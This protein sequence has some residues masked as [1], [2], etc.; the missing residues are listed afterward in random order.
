M[1]PF[2]GLR[3]YSSIRHTSGEPSIIFHYRRILLGNV[4]TLFC[5]QS[6]R[7]VNL[8]DNNAVVWWTRM[9]RGT[10][11]CTVARTVNWVFIVIF[12]L[13][14]LGSVGLN[15]HQL[16]TKLYLVPWCW[17]CTRLTQVAIADIINLSLHKMNTPPRK[18][19]RIICSKTNAFTNVG[20]VY[21]RQIFYSHRWCQIEVP[22]YCMFM[23]TETGYSKVLGSP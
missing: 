7:K 8:W 18:C 19:T 1:L 11:S 23:S 15:E 22:D 17:S 3:R 21:S 20:I 14:I 9:T 16:P 6:G 13:P 5:I 12:F 2:S 4:P 10:N